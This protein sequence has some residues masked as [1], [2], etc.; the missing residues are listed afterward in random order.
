M[1]LIPLFSSFF[2]LT[3]FFIVNQIDELAKFTA[4]ISRLEGFQSK[5]ELISKENW[6]EYNRNRQGVKI[7]DT[8]MLFMGL[9]HATCKY[10][11]TLLN[12]H[13]YFIGLNSM[14]NSDSIK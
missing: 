12:S 11:F 10:V 14:I 2:G 1:N 5:V 4:G 9:S 7:H 3:V 8:F 13:F 6:K